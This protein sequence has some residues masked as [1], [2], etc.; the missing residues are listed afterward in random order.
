MNKLEAFG[1]NI[2]STMSALAKEHNAVNLAQ[3]FPDFEPY[4][5]LIEFAHQA[6]KDGHNQYAPMIGL[7]ALREEIAN[8]TKDCYQFFPNSEIEITITSGAT[9]AVFSTITAIIHPGD[10]VIIFE[11]A[12]DIYLPAIHL[13]GGKAVTI[14]LDFPN[15]T[16]NFEL[17]EK[18]ISPRTKLIILNSPHNP[19]GSVV[20]KED[21]ERLAMVIE[22]KDIFLLSDEV[23]EHIVFD[24]QQHFSAL[25]NEILRQKSFVIS[26]LGK[27]Y[28]LTGWRVGYVIAPEKLTKL[29]RSVHQFNTFSAHTP[30]QIAFSKIL[31]FK[32]LY[33]NLSS[34]IQAKRDLFLANMKTSGFEP[35]KSQGTYFQLMS[36]KNISDIS[37]ID[38]AKQLVIQKGVASIPISVFY[39]QKEDHKIVRFC[40]AK[41]D[42]TL[43]K[44]AEKLCKI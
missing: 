1:T 22:N 33:Q 37:D 32:Y 11:P 13:A 3:G 6:M 38:F 42:E 41:K 5:R 28:H 23:Y 36:Y 26:S 43:L 39:T 9:E 4:P 29:F 19:T 10:E 35:I 30:S 12:F 2:F 27:T 24:N 21:F 8:K 25:Q 7:P 16:I 18:S 20:P 40:I 15:F 14:P 31:A 17:L 34:F 44:A